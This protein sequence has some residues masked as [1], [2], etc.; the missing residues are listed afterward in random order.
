MILK[1]L[2]INIMAGVHAVH[3]LIYR[4]STSF[5]SWRKALF[6]RCIVADVFSINSNSSCFHVLCVTGSKQRSING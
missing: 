5:M 6:L 4:G 3:R 1:A 2:K